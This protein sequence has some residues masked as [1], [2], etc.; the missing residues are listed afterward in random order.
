VIST[1]NY[2]HRLLCCQWKQSNWRITAKRFVK[3]GLSKIGEKIGRLKNHPILTPHN[4]FYR[5]IKI[6]R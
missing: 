3:I 6:G 4:I 5:M 2:L 1:A